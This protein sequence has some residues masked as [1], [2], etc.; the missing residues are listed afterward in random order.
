MSL[1]GVELTVQKSSLDYEEGARGG[2]ISVAVKLLFR[3]E[4]C[5]RSVGRKFKAAAETRFSLNEWPSVSICPMY[6]Q[7]KLSDF[8][9]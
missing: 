6:H 7:P 8:A 3:N 5:G 2:E 1:D 9:T 4:L